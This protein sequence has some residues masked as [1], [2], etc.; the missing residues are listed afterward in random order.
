MIKY[1][2]G[3]D[4]VDLGGVPLSSTKY[5]CIKHDGLRRSWSQLDRFKEIARDLEADDHPKR[6]DEHLGK[7]VKH[8]PAPEKGK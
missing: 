1:G 7:L 2:F 6:F 5:R 8:K 3:F 4:A